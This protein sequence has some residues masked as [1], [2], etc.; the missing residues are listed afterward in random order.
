[1]N[2]VRADPGM[3]FIY[4]SMRSKIF[5]GPVVLTDINLRITMSLEGFL[6]SWN[7]LC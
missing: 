7:V 1:M 4:L 6:D 2:L 5:I 3:V